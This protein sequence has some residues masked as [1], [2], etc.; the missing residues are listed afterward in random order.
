MRNE[1]AY[2][3]GVVLPSCW[4]GSD[5]RVA[6]YLPTGSQNHQEQSGPEASGSVGIRNAGAAPIRRLMT[7][8]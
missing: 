8:P 1:K 4:N 7:Y 3:Q 2:W 6:L 5:T